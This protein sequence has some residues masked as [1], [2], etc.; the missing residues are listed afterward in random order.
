VQERGRVQGRAGVPD[1]RRRA[2]RDAWRELRGRQRGRQAR[3][4][5]RATATPTAATACASSPLRRP[6]LEHHRLSS[7]AGVHDHPAR[8]G[9]RRA[10]LWLPAGPRAITWTIPATGPS[11]Q[12]LLPVPTVAA[13]AELVMSV[14]DP[15]QEGRRRERARSVRL[16]P[17]HGAVS[18]PA[19]QRSGACTDLVAAD[20]F[21]SHVPGPASPRG[22][23]RRHDLR[24]A[25][26]L[27]PRRRAGGQPPAHLP[28]FG[29]RCC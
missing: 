8:R 4:G 26:H 21:Y 3:R 28:D 20:E 15:G 10:V 27:Q 14:D 22:P 13:S 25:D 29:A 18:V 1:Q 9:Q 5:P 24:H 23:R 11:S 19:A 7:R 17:L 6:L 12:I 16:H 2:R